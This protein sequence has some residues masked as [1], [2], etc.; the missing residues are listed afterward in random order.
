MGII[1]APPVDSKE[2]ANLKQAREKEWETRLGA[3][4]YYARVLQRSRGIPKDFCSTADLWPQKMMRSSGVPA[5]SQ[6]LRP[7]LL[8]PGTPKAQH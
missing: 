6:R 1:A 7:S 8:P 5:P 3:L 2:D 4:E